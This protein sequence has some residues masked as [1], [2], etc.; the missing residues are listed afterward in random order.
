M[1]EETILTN[2]MFDLPDLSEIKDIS[3][4]KNYFFDIVALTLDI[5]CTIISQF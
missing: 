3:E 5:L 1:R 4:V 2:Q